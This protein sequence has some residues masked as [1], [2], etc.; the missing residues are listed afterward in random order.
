MESSLIR[1]SALAWLVLV[2]T[3]VPAV[4]SEQVGQGYAWLMGSFV[5]PDDDRFIDGDIDFAGG[6][7]GVGTAFADN[8]NLELGYEVLDFDGGNDFD[9]DIVKLNVLNVYNR[10]GW[11]SPFILGGVG[12]SSSD[13]DVG[14]SDDNL[15]AQA[16]LGF[17]VDFSDRLALRY[18]VLGRWENA[19]A[20]DFLDTMINVGVQVAFGG[21]QPIVAAAPAVPAD[22]DGDGVPDSRDNCPGTP[23]GLAVNTDGCPFDTDKD[24]VWDVNDKCPGTPVG[25]AV[26]AQ[27]CELDSD[28]DGVVDRF[29]ECPNSSPGVAVDIKGCEIK[30]E[31]RLPGVNFETNSDQLM[32]GAQ[33]VLDN[34]AAT[35]LKNPSLIIEVAGHTDSDGAAEY[36]LNLSM[37]RAVTVRDYLIR[38]DVPPDRLTAR[39]YGEEQP[40]AQGGSAEAK[41]ANRRVVLR[42][43]ER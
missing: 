18:E 23:A 30:S 28:N 37:R 17:L 43:L 21:D 26:D 7:G 29:D 36:N 42:V 40:I 10:A 11:F 39:G 41:A 19:R 6:Q 1:V 8:W 38:R 4:A 20:D 5:N 2:S 31:I 22:S 16:G 15:Q 25:A 35:L 27:G 13:F 9:Q 24:G 14:G 34:A 3:V 33:S 12:Y 32:S